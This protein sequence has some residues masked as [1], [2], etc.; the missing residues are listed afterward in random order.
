MGRRHARSVLEDM[1]PDAPSRPNRI[2]GLA[3]RDGELYRA[4]TPPVSARTGVPLAGLLTQLRRGNDAGSRLGRS[5]TR[6]PR[7]RAQRWLDG[8]QS[9]DEGLKAPNY[10]TPNVRDAVVPVM[11]D[12]L[13]TGRLR[14]RPAPLSNALAAANR[15]RLEAPSPAKSSSSKPT[16]WPWSTPRSRKLLNTWPVPQPRTWRAAGKV[17]CT[18]YPAARRSWPSTP[19][20]AGRRGRRR[21]AECDGDRRRRAGPDLRARAAIPKPG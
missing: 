11:N 5:S 18:S 2:D 4:S 21:A 8:S 10:Y 3:A 14:R 12:V 1:L 6:G 13:P 19:P 17:S 20:P 15:R 9:E 7:Q 16:R